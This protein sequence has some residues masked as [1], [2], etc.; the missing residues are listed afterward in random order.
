YV[1][2]NKFINLTAKNYNVI[3]RDNN[4]CVAA[5]LVNVGSPEELFVTAFKDSIIDTIKMGEQTR[6]DFTPATQSGIIPAYQNI[7]WSPSNG[8]SCTDCKSP[9]ASPYISTIYDLDVRYHK[10]CIAKSTIKVPV[11][12]PVD[13]F[14]PSAFTPANGDGLND[15]LRVYGVGIKKVLLMI[16]NRWGEKVFE[17]DHLSMG[18]D[19]KF[20][21]DMQTAGVFTFRAEVEYLNGEKRTKQ[22]SVTLIR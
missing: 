3:V 5:R 16:F 18:W 9:N 11:H 22:G 12:L 14:V 15:T 17:S 19:G 20:K 4:N 1:S 21:G 2:G 6:I 7:L 8:L 13:F 10:N